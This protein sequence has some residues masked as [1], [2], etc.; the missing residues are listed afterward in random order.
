[1]FKNM[2]ETNIT[3]NE[4]EANLFIFF[5]ENYTN[6]KKLL[7]YRVFD[8]RSKTLILHIDSFGQINGMEIK[9][10]VR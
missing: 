7:D 3:L 1:M 4:E 2:R 9:V 10:R 8:E 5:Q 6:I